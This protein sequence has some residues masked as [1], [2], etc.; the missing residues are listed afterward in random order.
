M[1]HFSFGWHVSWTKVQG[2]FF[3]FLSSDGE[4]SLNILSCIRMPYD[5]DLFLGSLR[6]SKNSFEFHRLSSCSVSNC[7]T[8]HS[9]LSR[10][11][12]LCFFDEMFTTGLRY[13]APEPFVCSCP[14]WS[15]INCEA[16]HAAV[17]GDFIV[18]LL[19]PVNNLKQPYPA[20]MHLHWK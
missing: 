8:A 16:Q 7:T 19:W 1:H 5:I 2:F 11:R 10:T 14:H 6:W 18:A 9:F 3:F 20:G 17:V 4:K 13:V 15:K 12:P